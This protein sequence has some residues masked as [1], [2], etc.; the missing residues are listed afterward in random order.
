MRRR[1]LIKN[2]AVVAG[3]LLAV[4]AWA[5][6]WNKGTI[7]TAALFSPQ[8]EALLADVVATIIPATDTPGAKELGVDNLIKKILAD[9]YEKETGEMF[10][11]GLQNVDTTA[12]TNFNKSFSDCSQQERLDVLKQIEKEERGTE[13]PASNVRNEGERPAPTFFRLAK[14]LTILGYTNSE[15]VMTK[16]TNYVVMPGHYHGCVPYNKK[17]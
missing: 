1:T 15:Y 3:G 2:M 12:K 8:N 11:K 16:L 5:I 4:P 7:H 13:Q 14:E 9:C 10:A 17:A 6:N